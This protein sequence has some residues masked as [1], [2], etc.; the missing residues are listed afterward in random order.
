MGM[1]LDRPS[2]FTWKR[3]VIPGFAPNRKQKL[4]AETDNLLQGL[5]GRLELSMKEIARHFLE[6]KCDCRMISGFLG[7]QASS[8][9]EAER[10]HEQWI[11]ITKVHNHLHVPHPTYADKIFVGFLRHISLDTDAIR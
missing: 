9:P 2:R 6:I 10:R 3:I 8:N 5:R 11:I 1:S 4:D 7:Q